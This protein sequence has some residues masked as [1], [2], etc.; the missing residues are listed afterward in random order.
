MVNLHSCT[1]MSHLPV[2]SAKF[3]SAKIDRQFLSNSVKLNHLVTCD[4]FSFKLAFGRKRR[5]SVV[6]TFE[7]RHLGNKNL[8]NL[9]ASTSQNVNFKIISM[10]KIDINSKN[11]T[12]MLS[13]V[14][15]KVLFYI[16]DGIFLVTRP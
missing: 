9:Q 14:Y 16:C 11:I 6:G 5:R 4:L 13:C 10:S 8:Y 7:N 15:F 3:L 2:S 12:R 1:F